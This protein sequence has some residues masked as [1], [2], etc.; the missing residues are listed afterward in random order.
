MGAIQKT[1]KITEAMKLVSAAKV[2]RAQ[3]SVTRSRP[4]AEGAV[5]M[6]YELNRQL[7]RQGIESILQ[8]RRPVKTVLLVCVSADRGLC[9]SYNNAVIKVSHSRW[10]LS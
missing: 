1:Q 5:Q 4:F 10:F 8:L 7:Q 6:L 3:E 2:R 9:G